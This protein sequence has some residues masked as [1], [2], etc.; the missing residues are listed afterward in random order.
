MFE[1]YKIIKLNFC[2]MLNS[3]VLTFQKK[4]LQLIWSMLSRCKGILDLGNHCLTNAPKT[5]E[6]ASSQE[7]TS[8][9]LTVFFVMSQASG[10]FFSYYIVKSL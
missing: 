9:I 8:L 1:A 10:S 3:R 6:D 7:A 4:H 2:S 5:S